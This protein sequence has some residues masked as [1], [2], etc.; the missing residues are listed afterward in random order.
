MVGLFELLGV[1][2]LWSVGIL[3]WLKF[4]WYGCD[5]EVEIIGYLYG[6]LYLLL[7]VYGFV[8]FI[9]INFVFLVFGWYDGMVW[10]FV[11]LCFIL[12]FWWLVVFFWLMYIY[13]LEIVI[14]W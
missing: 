12:V 4:V 10:N 13:I 6:L 14:G 2:I 5:F 8:I 3:Y 11:S 1:G 9:G 7:E